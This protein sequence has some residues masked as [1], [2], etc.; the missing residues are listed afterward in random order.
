MASPAHALR[1]ASQPKHAMGFT[2]LEVM[3]AL[4]ILATALGGLYLSVA[5]SMRNAFHAR[6]VMQATALCRTKLVHLESKTMTEGF[7]NNI[8]TD[9]KSGRFFDGSDVQEN[10]QSPAH[11]FQNDPQLASTYSE[12]RWTV[13]IE[14]VLMPGLDSF[15][16]SMSNAGPNAGQGSNL[17][18]LGGLIQPFLQQKI[19]RITVQVRW[20]EPAQKN[21]SVEV[22]TFMTDPSPIGPGLLE[23]TKPGS[24]P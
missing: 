11:P 12:F 18:A 19:R 20:D 5:Q 15:L 3:V 6:K 16:G 24:A 1:S 7:F 21:Q 23:A 17:P 22:S 14:P 8:A 10:T 2:L 9:E 13:R 4:G